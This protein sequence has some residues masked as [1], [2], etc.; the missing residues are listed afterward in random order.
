M[1]YIGRTQLRDLNN[2]SLREYRIDRGMVVKPGTM[3]K[4]LTIV[5]TVMN[6]AVDILE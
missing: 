5:T 4:E 6:Y 3:Q 2:A 1:P